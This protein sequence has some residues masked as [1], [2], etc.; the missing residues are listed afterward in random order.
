MEM[1]RFYFDRYENRKP[2]SSIPDSGFRTLFFQFFGILTIMLGLVYL[3]WRW[4][5][6]LNPDA[7]FF[8][9]LL[10]LAE[11]LS[12]IG[13]ILMV[14]TFWSNRDAKKK[15]PVHYLSD[16]EDLQ[17]RPDRPLKIDIFIATYN[18]EV[19]LVRKS[20]VDAKNVTYPYP[21]V[22]VKIYVLDDGRRDGR[23]PAKENMKAVAE[24]EG[25]NYLIRDDNKG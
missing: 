20:I 6:S 13:T 2:Y 12:F 10:A 3:N 24:E 8:S 19:E 1:K 15:P 7:L 9:I 22:A 5:Y 25:V 14:F 21:D 23:D 18:E 17:G 4:V 11:T 16:I